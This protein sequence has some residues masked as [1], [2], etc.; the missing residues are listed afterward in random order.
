VYARGDGKLRQ[1][2]SFLG[3]GSYQEASGACLGTESKT[4]TQMNATRQL[5]DSLQNPAASQNRRG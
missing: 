1:T 5:D 4:K 3:F 2:K